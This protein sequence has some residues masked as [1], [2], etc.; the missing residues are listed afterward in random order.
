M[1]YRISIFFLGLT[2]L[3]SS[4]TGIADRGKF[5]IEVS[6]LKSSKGSLRVILYEKDGWLTEENV[7]GRF[8]APVRNGQATVETRSLPYGEYAMFVYHDE[9]DNDE[10]D[11]NLFK[12]PKEG[13]GF[14]NNPKIGLSKP[15]FEE[16]VVKLRENRKRIEVRLKYF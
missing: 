16:T 11:F 14:S 3:L 9:N 2:L 1:K 12:M 5:V 4:L 13:I 7:K 8:D 10:V 15:K 6:D